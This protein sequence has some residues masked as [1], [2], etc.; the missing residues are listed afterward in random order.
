LVAAR[1]EGNAR[2]A[3]STIWGGLITRG[4]IVNRPFRI[5]HPARG[6]A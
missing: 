3:T 5:K 1:S 6:V 4:P 2:H